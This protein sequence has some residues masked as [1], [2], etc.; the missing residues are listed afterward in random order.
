MLDVCTLRIVRAVTLQAVSYV[1]THHKELITRTCCVLRFECSTY[2]GDFGRSRCQ[3]RLQQGI[4]PHLTY[5]HI[6]ATDTICVCILCPYINVVS[7]YL[8]YLS[9]LVASRSRCPHPP[10]HYCPATP[11]CKQQTESMDC[12]LQLLLLSDSL[13]HVHKY[14]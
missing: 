4:A 14:Y 11:S 13:T 2:G 8:Y 12:R 9:I 1:Y 5:R 3:G 6:T 10:L 7:I